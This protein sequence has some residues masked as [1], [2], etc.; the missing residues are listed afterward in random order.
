MKLKKIAII[1][2]G[3][4]GRRH[5]R[6]IKE[7]SPDI[8]VV[9]V[10]SGKGK[11]WP[12]EKMAAYVV[13]SIQDAVNLNIQAAIISSPTT[14][15]VKQAE[16]LVGSKIPLLIEKPLSNS[17]VGVKELQEVAL[18]N[19]CLILVGYVLRFDPAAR[20]F[21]QWLE[22][23]QLGRVL[24]ARVECGSYLPDWRPEQDYHTTVSASKELGGGVLSELSHELDYLSWFFGKPISVYGQLRNSGELGIDVED[25]ADLMLKSCDEYSIAVQIDFNR[26]YPTRVCSVQ[27]TNG[28]LTWNAIEK[29]TTWKPINC[30]EVIDKFEFERD[31]IYI[32]QLKNFIESVETRIEPAVSLHDGVNVMEL[33]HAVMV[34]NETGKKI[35]I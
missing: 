24:H 8:E 27:T 12:E 23:K 25:Q 9:L 32:E 1:G 13:T 7:I 6:L 30:E 17:M 34:S 15:H 16:Q 26:R 11:E 18:N 3:S 29:T 31:Y 20:R 19:S 21:K 14:L 4:I 35:M 5:L 2:L 28:E 10:R 33:I 22:E